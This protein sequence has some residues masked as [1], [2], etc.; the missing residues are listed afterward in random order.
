MNWNKKRV[1]VTGSSGFVGTALCNRLRSQG[2][3]VTEYDLKHGLDVRDL[4]TLEHIASSAGVEIIYH[5]AAQ[6]QVLVAN[7]YPLDCFETN[8][9]GTWNVLEVSRR[10]PTLQ[11]L[12][13]ASSDKVYG[14]VTSAV[15]EAG[16]FL[17]RNPYDVSKACADNLANMYIDLYKMP[18]AV[19]RS[20]NIYGA[21]D[22]NYTRLIPKT[23]RA[24]LAGKQP[25]IYGDGN[26]TREFVFIR[27]CI[28]G[29]LLLAD[30]KPGAYNFGGEEMTVNAVVESI[31]LLGVGRKARHIGEEHHEIRNQRL[32]DTKAREELGW[33]RTITFEQGIHMTYDLYKWEE[34]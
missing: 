25:V 8:T 15:D 5:L 22:E 32:D 28:D 6:S 17:A 26:Q 12:V 16:V 31:I 13:I 27:D 9:R 3:I 19:S 10:L 29:Y 34:C 2:A 14:S 33:N 23:I 11:Q 21:G 20:C 4:Y 7:D 18:I 30:A 1:L 24:V